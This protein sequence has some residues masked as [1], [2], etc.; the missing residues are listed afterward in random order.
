MIRS[1]GGGGELYS[2]SGPIKPV[3]IVSS[4]DANDIRFSQNT[5]SYNKTE[6]SNGMKY[7]YDDLVSS[8]KKMA[9]RESQWMSS[10]CQMEK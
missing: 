10:K 9:G 7:T 1:K 3:G 2:V 8:M 5:V 6:Q 4:F